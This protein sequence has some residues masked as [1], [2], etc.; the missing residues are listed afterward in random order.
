MLSRQH[1][2]V[3]AMRPMLKLH[4]TALVLQVMFTPA[5]GHSVN[6]KQGI[7]VKVTHNAKSATIACTG[8]SFTLKPSFDPAWLDLG[9]I[10]PRF[11]GQKPNEALLKL[12][13][14]MDVDMEVQLFAAHCHD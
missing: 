4:L 1:S 9:A 12:V 7:M 11:E 5:A 14:P 13:N 6:Y 2:V 8:S 10:L 3:L